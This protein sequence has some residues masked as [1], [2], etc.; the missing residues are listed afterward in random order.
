M[1]LP[2]IIS[3]DDH[4]IE[5]PDLWLSRMP[6][7]FRAEAPRVVR[8]PWERG[9]NKVRGVSVRPSS[10]GP[11]VD[12]WAF[13]DIRVAVLTVEGRGR[14]AAREGDGRA[15]Q[16]HADM[17]PGCYQAKDRLADMDAAR[18]ER[19]LCFPNVLRFA[20]QLFLWMSDRDLA[21]ATLRAY[22]DWMV[23]RG[24]P[25]TAAG[26]CSRSAS[27]HS[28]TRS[29]LPRRSAATRHAG[30]GPSPFPSSLPTWSFRAS[31]TPAATG[32]RSSRRVT[33]PARSSACT[34]DRRR[35]L[36][37]APPTPRRQ[38]ACRR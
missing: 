14:A 32:C 37:S 33:R 9:P 29:W 23:E 1:P 10:S 30:S 21:L 6:A 7:R 22:N 5:P 26:G 38:L 20:G 11:E 28:G 24:G 34:S 2:W 8:M 13:G 19:S 27:S 31:T 36:H 25:A 15:H 16:L 17:R 4:V 18:V 3:V 12:F 35:R